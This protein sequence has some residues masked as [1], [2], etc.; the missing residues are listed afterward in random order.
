MNKQKIVLDTNVVVSALLSPLGNPAKIYRM[1]L[2]EI[3]ILVY[4]S[5][6]L[7]EYK[8]VLSR[9]R[10]NI[11]T[12]DIDIVFAAIKQYG[13]CV[14]PLSGTK[15]MIDESDRIFYD[16][17]KHAAAYLITG[18]IRHYPQELFILTPRE[19]LET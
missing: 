13:E 9:P 7:D 12:D 6:I 1:F 19:F 17:S 4:S 14:E 10:L 2:T 11:P 15:A 16:A 8:D 5:A 3:L 18:N